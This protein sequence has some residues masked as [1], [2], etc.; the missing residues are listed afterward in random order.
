[1]VRN[2]VRLAVLTVAML[3]MAA[4]AMSAQSANGSQILEDFEGYFTG[5]RAMAFCDVAYPAEDCLGT[6]TGGS[7]AAATLAFPAA[8][9]SQVYVGTSITLSIFDNYN[10]SWPA[11]SALVSGVDP[12]RLQVWEYDIDTAGEILRFDGVTAANTSNVFFNFGDDL[13]PQYLTRF[14][15]SSASEFAIDDLRLG[16]PDVAPGVPEPSSWAMLVIGFAA[17]GAI[18]R[19]RQHRELA[20]PQVDAITDNQ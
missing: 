16:L 2:A 8:S 17:T 15:F 18:L 12:I 5:P 20:Q 14:V 11:V 7:V 13:S 9:G 1:M 3:A 4:P 19:R 6:L 10:Y